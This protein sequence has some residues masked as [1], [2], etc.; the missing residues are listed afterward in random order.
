M[1]ELNLWFSRARLSN[2]LKII[3]LKE[4]KS[5]KNIFEYTKNFDNNRNCDIMNYKI[6]NELKKA[7][8]ENIIYKT[9]EKILKEDINI[10]NFNDSLYPY[11]LKYYEDSPAVLFYKGNIEPLNKSKSVAIVGSRKSTFY[12]EKVTKIVSKALSENNISIISGMAKGIDYNAQLSSINSNGYTCAVL[13]S[14]IDVIYPKQ[15]KDLYKSICEKGCVIS[16]F[17]PGTPPFSYNFP[18]RNRIISALSD[19]VIVVEASYRSGSLITATLALEQGKDVFSVPGSIFS[20]ESIGTNKLIK[21][22]AFVLTSLDDI[23]QYLGVEN[24]KIKDNKVNKS[25]NKVGLEKQIYNVLTDE[26]IHI[27][28]II[29]LINIDIKRLY[30]VLFELQLREEVI[31]LAGNYYV[32]A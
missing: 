19:V 12:G 14:G 30:E 27:D 6:V 16:E 17:Y 20:K 9:K 24:H 1:V 8:N 15:N 7:W 31:C 25:N 18:M 3:L 21:E 11:K 23:F 29:R 26:P 10:I 4:F 2:K 28:D 32:K 5:I 22:G 13:G